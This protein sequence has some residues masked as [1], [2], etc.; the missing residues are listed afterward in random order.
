MLKKK[1]KKKKNIATKIT[2][3]NNRTIISGL[4][5]RSGEENFKLSMVYCGESSVQLI[6]IVSPSFRIMLPT[7]CISITNK[8]KMT[9]KLI[10]LLTIHMKTRNMI[11]NHCTKCL[12]QTANV[13]ENKR[14]MFDLNSF[15]RTKINL[16]KMHL[17][18]N[19]TTSSILN[20]LRTNS[21]KIYFS[22]ILVKSESEIKEDKKKHI[23]NLTFI[24]NY[25]TNI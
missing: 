22:I 3:A 4:M 17:R 15:K 14:K 19:E 25:L 21:P 11:F 1:R 13:I 2:N 24:L 9:K 8:Q 16:K 18:P 10:N 12:K 23:K 5:L 20:K 7:G 6:S